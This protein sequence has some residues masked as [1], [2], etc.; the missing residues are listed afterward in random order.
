MIRAVR[1]ERYRYIHVYSHN[2]GIAHLDTVDGEGMANADLIAAAPDNY[3]CNIELAAIVRE[4]CAAYNHPLP[5]ASLDRSDSAIA[6]AR[7]EN[8]SKSVFPYKNGRYFLEW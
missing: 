7:G 3:E 4:L 5:Q 6:K 1:A 2:G 8:E